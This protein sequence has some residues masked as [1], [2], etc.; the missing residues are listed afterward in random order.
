V[1]N[2]Q[3]VSDPAGPADGWPDTLPTRISGRQLG[4]RPAVAA[5]DGFLRTLFA[6]ARPELGLLPE[7]VR[8]QLIRLQFEAQ[9]RQY[10]AYPPE[11]G[12]QRAT[13]WI[14]E[15]RGTDGAEPVGRCYLLPGPTEI[16]LLDLAV[17]ERLR[18]QG[19]GSSVLDRLCSVAERAGVPLRLTVWQANAGAIRLYRRLGFVEDGADGGYLRM[20][21]TAPRPAPENAEAETIG[22]ANDG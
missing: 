9:R 17:R 5:D 2:T 11:P 7:P 3:E 6:E 21:W 22:D 4:R 14:L 8:E 20:H 15:L 12:G 1:Q 19:I 18:G 10:Q 16:K 13:D